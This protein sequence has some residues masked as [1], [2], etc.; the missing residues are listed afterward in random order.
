MGE[1]LFWAGWWASRSAQ[2]RRSEAAFCDDRSLI[3]TS[4]P[5]LE[6]ETCSIQT[7][8]TYSHGFSTHIKLIFIYNSFKELVLR[9]RPCKEQRILRCFWRSFGDNQCTEAPRYSRIPLEWQRR[10][11]QRGFPYKLSPNP[12]RFRSSHLPWTHLS[13]LEST[14]PELSEPAPNYIK[15]IL[16]HELKKK[17][18]ASHR[19]RL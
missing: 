11:A 17:S 2:A 6:P 3:G 7:N 8:S 18:I 5:S 12:S 10:E 4:L 9:C 16:E 19:Q 15:S 1:F 14:F 13:L